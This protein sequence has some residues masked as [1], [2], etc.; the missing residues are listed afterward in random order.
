MAFIPNPLFEQEMEQA[1]ESIEAL[2][3][4]AEGV[5]DEASRLMP[6]GSDDRR[7]RTADKFYVDSSGETV[8]VSN[9]DRSFYHLSEFGSANNPPY[10]PLRPAVRAAG[11]RFEEA[12]KP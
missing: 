12:P 9:A 7:G 6:R 2:T 1:P 8:F 5:R 4:A 10:A 11:L 3:A